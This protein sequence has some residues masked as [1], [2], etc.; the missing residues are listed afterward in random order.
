MTSSKPADLPD[1]FDVL[2]VGGGAAGLYAALCL[3]KHLQIGL[4]T[5]DTLSLSAS[6]WAQGGIAA[7]I[8]PEDSEQLHIADTLK[9][10][11]GLCDLE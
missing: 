5:K 9:A 11:A 8:A 4:I 1:R 10:G 6:D 7:A 3:P 2:I